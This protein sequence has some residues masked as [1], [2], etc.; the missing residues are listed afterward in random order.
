MKNY[1]LTQKII[2][3]FIILSSLSFIIFGFISILSQNTQ[4]DASVLGTNEIVYS[5]TTK[6]FPDFKLRNITFPLGKVLRINKP[7]EILIKQL[8]T[9]IIASDLDFEI[10]ENKLKLNSGV[11]FLETLEKNNTE[12]IVNNKSIKLLNNSKIIINLS[13]NKF[14]VI[15]GT[16][17]GE[18]GQ[19]V[20]Q[21]QSARWIVDSWN[22]NQFLNSDI[23]LDSKYDDLEFTLWNLDYEI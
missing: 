1:N 11:L 9:R 10:T 23:F 21:D 17:V 2:F 5:G 22:I 15:E 3:T 19:I 16:V 6:V 7:A 20:E 12:V 13:E 4:Q 18:N 8:N 14:Y